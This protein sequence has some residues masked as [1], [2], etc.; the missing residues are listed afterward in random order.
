MNKLKK[1][2]N[3]PNYTNNPVKNNFKKIAFY[4]EFFERDRTLFWDFSWETYQHP[5]LRKW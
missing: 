4:E 5:R 2:N 1:K 3:L